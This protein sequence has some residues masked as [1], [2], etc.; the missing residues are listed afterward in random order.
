M[1]SYKD[2]MDNAY[3]S[4]R[5][6][7]GGRYASTKSL[8]VAPRYYPQVKAP[9]NRPY[10][11]VGPIGHPVYATHSFNSLGPTNHNAQTRYLVSDEE[12]E[13]E[14][15]DAPYYHRKEQF[16]P[17]TQSFHH[18]DT[19]RY[20]W[21][22]K[23]TLN[24]NQT[25]LSI[26]K[27]QQTQ[28]DKY[29]PLRH[30][31]AKAFK[32]LRPK[33]KFKDAKPSPNSLE[34]WVYVPGKAANLC[35]Q[36][37]NYTDAHTVISLQVLAAHVVLSCYQSSAK[38][39]DMLEPYLVTECTRQPKYRDEISL[40]LYLPLKY[41]VQKCSVSSSAK[42]VV[43]KTLPQN[44]IPHHMSQSNNFSLRTPAGMPVHLPSKTSTS[45]MCLHQEDSNSGYTT[46]DRQQTYCVHPGEKN[47]EDTYL[48]VD[49]TDL[50]AEQ[51]TDTSL[52]KMHHL[53]I[54]KTR[55]YSESSTYV[56][57]NSSAFEPD[58]DYNSFSIRD[59]HSD[60]SQV[61]QGMC[62][63]SYVSARTATLREKQT[64]RGGVSIYLWKRLES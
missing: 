12:Y 64:T 21:K 63:I 56:G 33:E 28:S 47:T 1:P 24:S 17:S 29:I 48:R 22:D 60:V 7:S 9:W 18:D 54:T 4:I 5:G 58:N 35:A 15:W 55:E 23:E 50:E 27:Y 19:I 13:Y 43:P 61:A 42:K 44:D 2:D 62:E 38:Y 11:P 39:Q 32:K 34:V 41:A 25:I 31:L 46:S 45:T 20:K 36:S 8:P 6:I 30:R 26:V 14:C 51:A 52:A 49:M 40:H 53:D 57:Y 59:Q 37:S 10:L 3:E 16:S